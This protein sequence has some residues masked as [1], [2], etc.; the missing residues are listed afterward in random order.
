MPVTIIDATPPLTVEE[1]LVFNLVV[2]Q[3]FTME[4]PVGVGGVPPYEY[5]V[6]GFILP[7]YGISFDPQTRIISGTPTRTVSDGLTYRVTDSA[8]PANVVTEGFGVVVAAAPV[9]LMPTLPASL[10]TFTYTVGDNV[11]ELL[12]AATGGDLPIAYSVTGLFTPGIAFNSNTRRLEGSPTSP[13]SDFF[14]YHATDD[15]GDTATAGAGIVVSADT[16]DLVM[17]TRSYNFTRGVS[18]FSGVPAAQGGTPPYSYSVTE[19]VPGMSYNSDLHR[20]QGTPTST[21]VYSMTCVVTD[22]AGATA[23]GTYVVNVLA[24]T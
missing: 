1:I 7:S 14:S 10:G 17:P 21:G 11:S 13:S 6:T 12:P 22:D 16:D 20:I 24:P 3:F 5:A 23:S 15:D 19:N 4:L 2:G 9:D 18:S 8:T